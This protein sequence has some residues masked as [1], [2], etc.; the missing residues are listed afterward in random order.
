[1]TRSYTLITFDWNTEQLSQEDDT[2]T[3]G[4]TQFD[5][6]HKLPPMSERRE[7]P[8][9]LH[10]FWQPPADRPCPVALTRQS[11]AERL[12]DFCPKKITFA[13]YKRGI[14]PPLF[15]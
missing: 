11:H 14:A 2:L 10:K 4:L 8:R 7:V 3:H 9:H 6:R 13:K 12:K 5:L 15:N 1:M